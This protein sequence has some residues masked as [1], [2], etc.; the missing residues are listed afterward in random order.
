MSARM[1]E[2]L[3]GAYLEMIQE[4]DF[5][6]YNVRFPEEGL[7]GLSEL[8][9][10]GFD[11]KNSLAY[12][13]EVSTHILGFLYGLKAEDSVKK[14]LKKFDTQKEFAGKKL[15]D[16]KT[17][18]YQF[19]SPRVGKTDVEKL[20]GIVGLES[21]VNETYTNKINELR[22][23]AKK[24]TRQINNPAFRVLQILEHMKKVKN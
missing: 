22:L 16:F 17:I 24:I 2:Y 6:S 5:V 8:D 20:N 23:L 10:V 1:G 13:C 11:F 4:C 3:V 21:I 14:V 19:W 9:V 18:K 7:R 15:N 12:L